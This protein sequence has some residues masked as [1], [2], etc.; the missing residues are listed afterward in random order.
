V[1]SWILPMPS[2]D[3]RSKG[4]CRTSQSA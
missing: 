2:G 1:F 3:Q 4:Y